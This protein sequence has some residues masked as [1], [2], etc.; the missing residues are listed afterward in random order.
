MNKKLIKILVG[1]GFTSA[2]A[3][4]LYKVWVTYKKVK[5]EM[6]EEIEPLEALDV[7][8]PIIPEPVQKPVQPYF[9]RPGVVD[10][11][12]DLE[13]ED[14]LA[15]KREMEQLEEDEESDGGYIYSDT[16]SDITL[17]DY[18]SLH[19]SMGYSGEDEDEFSEVYLTLE[20][21]SR[22]VDEIPDGGEDDEEEEEDEEVRFPP[23]SIQ[24]L[25]QY[26]GMML[27][28]FEI[29]SEEYNILKRLYNIRY[30][31]L[32]EADNTIKTYMMEEHKQFFGPASVHNNKVTWGDVLIYFARTMDF[33]LDGGVTYWAGIMINNIGLTEGMGE[34]ELEKTL[35][36]L[37]M[38]IFNSPKGYGLFGLDEEQYAMVLSRISNSTVNYMSFTGQ[39]NVFMSTYEEFPV[40][41]LPP[42][43]DILWEEEE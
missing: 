12:L 39:Y 5:A 20:P 8:Q 18:E 31:P 22:L 23:N 15:Y 32:N 19:P 3:F 37:A 28:E 41:N 26:V 10:D 4:C 2:S 6:E 36:D 21:Q 40:N 11:S 25:N 14:Q 33:D 29:G 7:P 30:V 42:I 17:L 38:H 1:V 24:A 34:L 13:L 43:G 16:P 35:S 27:A 9:G